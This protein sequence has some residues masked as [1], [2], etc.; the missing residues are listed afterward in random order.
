MQMQ[1]TRSG[2][3]ESV[4]RTFKNKETKHVTEK[5]KINKEE[6]V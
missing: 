3:L 4:I 2:Y 6:L 5:I 1:S